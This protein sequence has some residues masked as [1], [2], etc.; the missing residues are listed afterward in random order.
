MLYWFHYAADSDRI[1]GITRKKDS[2]M[3]GGAAV[4]L[5]RQCNLPLK[6]GQSRCLHCGTAANR[7]ASSPAPGKRHTFGSVCG[8][9]GALLPEGCGHCLVCSTERD[10]VPFDGEFPAPLELPADGPAPYPQTRPARNTT[11][12]LRRL[13]G[14]LS[15]LIC[16][17]VVAL[18]G[19]GVWRQYFDTS[20]YRAGESVVYETAKG[21]LMLSHPGLETPFEVTGITLEGKAFTD[22]ALAASPNGRRLAY[23][24]ATG[25]LYVLDLAQA[26]SSAEGGFPATLLAEDVAGRVVFTQDGSHIVYRTADGGLFATDYTETWKLDDGVTGLIAV[27]NNRALYTRR[28]EKSGRARSDLYVDGILQGSG[29]WTLIDRDIVEV[30]DWTPGFDRILYTANRTD[31]E[32]REGVSLLSFELR[33]GSLSTLAEGVDIVADASAASNAALYLTRRQQIWSYSQF[34]D[35]DLAEADA[36]VTKPILEDYPE[37]AEAYSIYGE[38]ADLTDL[39]ETEELI[40]Q[41]IAYNEALRLWEEKTL[42]DE[43]RRRLHNRFASQSAPFALYDLYLCRNGEA[44]L[45]DTGVWVETALSREADTANLDKGY[46]LYER[47][48][49]DSLRKL[50]MSAI[51]EVPSLSEVNLNQY[52]LENAGRELVCSTLEGPSVLLYAGEGGLIQK[53]WRASPEVDGVYFT[54]GPAGGQDELYFAPLRGSTGSAVK[55]AAGVETLYG[56]FRTGMLYGTGDGALHLAQGDSTRRLGGGAPRFGSLENGG[57]T[58]LFYGA[59]SIQTASGELYLFGREEIPLAGDVASYDYRSDQLVYLGRVNAEHDSL[60]LYVWRAGKLALLEESF[61]G[62]LQAES[63]A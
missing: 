45:L 29:E 19:Y 58:L 57:A 8:K 11:E 23:G 33:L 18:T 38:G 50:K 49:K 37:L 43:V 40:E 24:A 51:W 46:A 28:E 26:V 21:K 2:F 27:E 6:D 31:S 39:E 10:A 53:L 61:R 32:G 52:F 22:G 54:V 12:T 20:S 42:R 17:M 62:A 4:E 30:L 44:V 59:Y 60:D 48:D 9:C 3:E 47:I 36:A 5:C 13:G 63:E 1:C 15:L 14:M 35:D 16:V 25:K 56:P 41:N 7:P 34:V 55:V